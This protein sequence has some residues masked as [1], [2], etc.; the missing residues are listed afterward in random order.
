MGHLSTIKDHALCMIFSTIKRLL[1]SLPVLKLN[2]TLGWRH[3]VILQAFS[4]R[5]FYI[6]RLHNCPLAFFARSTRLGPQ[7]H[8]LTVKENELRASLLKFLFISQISILLEVFSEI[9]F[10]QYLHLQPIVL[11]IKIQKDLLSTLQANSPSTSSKYKQP[12]C[13]SDA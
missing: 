9:S 6:N 3:I 12:K 10:C 7:S 2:G 13:S 4:R 11:R 1:H 5:V 8:S